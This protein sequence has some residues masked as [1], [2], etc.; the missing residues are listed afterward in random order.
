MAN[1]KGGAK[2]DFFP[3]YLA[4]LFIV[5]FAIMIYGVIKDKG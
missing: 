5:F 3:L 1:R 4:T 2:L